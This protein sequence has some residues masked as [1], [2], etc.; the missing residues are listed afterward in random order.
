[1]TD[2][3]SGVEQITQEHFFKMMDRELEKVENY[4]TTKVREIREELERVDALI[5]D[6]KGGKGD[7]VGLKDAVDR[8]GNEFLK[9]EKYVNLNFTGFHKI[10]KKHDKNLPNACSAFY[11][12]RLHQQQWVRGDF[13]DIIVN[14]SRLY[15]LIRG[16]EDNTAAKGDGA[17]DF[18]RKT[19]KYW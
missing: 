1:M 5:R 14:I 9:L 10:L 6:F 4:T 11:I 12:G 15:S 8:I 16:D 17:Q 2:L 19:T 13:S 18:M 3:Q 7:G